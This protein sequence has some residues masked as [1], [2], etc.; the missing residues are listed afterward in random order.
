[1]P[2]IDTSLAPHGV[3][4]AQRL[5]MAVA[6]HGDLAERHDL[7]LKSILDL[8]TK[9][10]KEKIAK[11]ILGAAN[12]MPD[13]AAAAFE[14]YAAIMIGVDKGSLTL[15]DLSAMTG[16]DRRIG[17]ANRTISRWNL[18]RHLLWNCL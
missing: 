15:V 17:E 10:D 1:M 7:E 16:R 5:V 11:F 8:S 3:L 9:K 14:G 12:R 6:E 4:A 18:P 2:G 13:T